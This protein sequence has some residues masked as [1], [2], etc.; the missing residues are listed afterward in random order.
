MLISDVQQSG[1]VTCTHKNVYIFLFI[2]FFIM[3]SWVIP[4]TLLIHPVYS[5]LLLLI[6]NSQSIS[7]PSPSPL[8]T[9]SLFSMSLSQFLFHRPVNLCHILD[10]TYKWYCTVFVILFL[11][12]SVSMII[13]R[14][15]HVAGN[16]II[17]LFFM[18]E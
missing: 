11:I 6:P 8:A 18:T 2:F 3:V 7:L 10:S 13:P 9:T 16:G 17:S 1:S 14:C 4:R 5:S 12:T 15:V